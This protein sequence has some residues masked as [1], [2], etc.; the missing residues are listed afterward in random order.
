MSYRILPSI[1]V[2]HSAVLVTMAWNDL[3]NAYECAC[4]LPFHI[5][6]HIFAQW[7]QRSITVVFVDLFPCLKGLIHESSLPSL[8]LDRIDRTII[9]MNSAVECHGKQWTTSQIGIGADSTLVVTC[10]THTDIYI[11]MYNPSILLSS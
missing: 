7:L 3:K 1:L 8:G 6:S 10:H 4:V 9:L 11:Y 2:K 5:L